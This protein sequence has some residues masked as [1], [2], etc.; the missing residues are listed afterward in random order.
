VEGLPRGI[1]T[2]WKSSPAVLILR[3]HFFDF[4]FWG[5]FEFYLLN[6]FSTVNQDP[7]REKMSTK[8][9]GQISCIRVPLNVTTGLG[10]VALYV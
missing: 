6:A 10:A 1:N 5:E 8:N 2:A 7:R 9:R 4:D 3:G